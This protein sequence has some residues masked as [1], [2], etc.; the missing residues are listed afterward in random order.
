MKKK[1]L[2]GSIIAVVLLV[3]M[4]FSPSITADVSKPDIEFVEEDATP[5]PI[6]LVLQLMTKLRNHKDIE[7]VESEEEILQIIEDDEELNGIFE[8][9]SVEDCDCEDDS[10]KLEWGFPV[11]CF[12]LIPFVILG[13]MAVMNGGPLWI[14]QIVYDI[15]AIFNCNWA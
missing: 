3:L 12:L 11:I 1:I 5:T 8:Q 15:G 13:W 6:V 9:L 10:S 2:I 7:N 14:G 4:S